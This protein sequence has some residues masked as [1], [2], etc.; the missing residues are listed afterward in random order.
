MEIKTT[1]CDLCKRPLSAVDTAGLS[2]RG[3]L[4]YKCSY[5]G[6]GGGA[7]STIDY[8]DLCIECSEDLRKIITMWKNKHL[9]K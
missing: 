7:G 4:Y 5:G 8:T 2:G 9:T 6:H 1:I 3:K